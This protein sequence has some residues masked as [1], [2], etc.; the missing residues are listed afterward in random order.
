MVTAI[1]RDASANVVGGAFRQANSH[2]QIVFSEESLIL[3]CSDTPNLFGHGRSDT[4]G[5]GSDPIAVCFVLPSPAVGLASPSF[6]QAATL[7]SVTSVSVGHSGLA[8]R[9]GV[10][11]NRRTRSGVIPLRLRVPEGAR[12]FAHAETARDN[13]R[14]GSAPR[15][16]I[17]I[18]RLSFV[19]MI[20][21]I[22]REIPRRRQH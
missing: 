2:N 12:E 11:A 18:S 1:P 6:S 14:R 20:L 16:K 19:S 17:D 22:E 13:L 21:G 3:C 9:R 4:P 5:A 10:S 7:R 8:G 15:S